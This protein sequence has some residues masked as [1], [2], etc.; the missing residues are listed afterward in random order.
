MPTLR[1]AT[2]LCLALVLSLLGLPL[3]QAADNRIEIYKDHTDGFY[4][5]TTSGTPVVKVANGIHNT[6]YNPN[7]VIFVIDSSTYGKEYAFKGLD[8]SSSEGYYSASWD[9]EHY[10]EPGW[11]A[12][13]YR[14]NGFKEIRI[15]FTDVTGPAP[16]AIFGND[17]LNE[18]DENATAPFLKD[19]RYYLEAGTTLPILGHTHAHWYFEQAGTYTISGYAVGVREDGSE[20]AS[21][22]FTEMF[23]VNK[24]DD[25]T[26]PDLTPRPLLPPD[27]PS[28]SPTATSAPSLSPTPSPSTSTSPSASAT[29]SAPT[30]P[31]PSPSQRVIHTEPTL[32]RAGH[33]D[34]FHVSPHQGGLALAAKDGTGPSYVYR[35]P[36][37][38]TLSI[39]ES[40]FTQLPASRAREL[41]PSG[42]FISEN[43]SS[44]TTLPFMGW[45]TSEVAPDFSSVDLEFVEVSGPGKLLMFSVSPFRGLTSPFTHGDYELTPGSVIRQDFPSHVHTNWLFT[46]AGTY[47]LTVRASAR[48]LDGGP[49]VVSNTGTYTFRVGDAPAPET[50]AEPVPPAPSRSA[51][52][53]I[54][55]HPGQRPSS[56]PSSTDA[57]QQAQPGSSQGTPAGTDNQQAGTPQAN[58]KGGFLASTGASG[59]V[60][61]LAL[62]LVLCTIGA[63]ALKQKREKAPSKN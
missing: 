19:G 8:R 30:S 2:L 13:G 32:I 37:S 41:A 7:D 47:T 29:P 26:R 59:L 36:E 34:L 57:S 61:L 25:D 5:V 16:F 63:L 24:H 39:D 62:A 53:R 33:V 60:P 6:L 14:D 17:P 20:V 50:S 10:F 4:V 42:Y 3:A 55:E 44:Q 22:P 49:E 11:N 28:P 46:E 48:P 15:E 43:G 40:A 54:N 45:D 27:A 52:P 18:E 51:T 1:K 38:L 58:S 21:Q 9:A 31:A 23:R 12:P 56:Q 35:S